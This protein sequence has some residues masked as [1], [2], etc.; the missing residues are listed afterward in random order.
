MQI[1]DSINHYASHLQRWFRSAKERIHKCLQLPS[2]DPHLRELAAGYA[3]CLVA[4]SLFST[5]KINQ[6]LLLVVVAWM[7]KWKR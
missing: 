6:I 7:F 4:L 5:I 1:P 2:L 3:F